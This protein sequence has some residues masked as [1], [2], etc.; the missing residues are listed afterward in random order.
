MNILSAALDSK[1]SLTPVRLGENNHV[2]YDWSYN[3]DEQI[4]QFFFQLVRTKNHDDLRSRLNDMLK[5]LTWSE[6]RVQLVTLLKILVQ[7]RDIVDGKGEYDLAYMQILVWYNYYPT[8]A[9]NMF[10]LFLNTTENPLDHQYG[11]WKDVKRFCQYIKENTLDG[12]DHVLIRGILAYSINSLR[13]EYEKAMNDINYNPTLIGKWLPREKSKYGW[14]FKKMAMMMNPQFMS[15]ATSRNTMIKA[16]NKQKMVL[17]KRLVYLNKRVDTVQI[18]MCDRDGKWSQIDFN[19]VTS[20]TMSKSKNAI[21]YVDKKGQLRGENSDRIQCR[22]NYK[23]HL[24]AAM[25]GDSSK[26]IHGK[27]CQV[28]EL[29]REALKCYGT[30]SGSEQSVRNTINMQWESNKSNNKGLEGKSI[31]CMC[32]TSGSMEVD[33]CL[34]LHNAIGMSIRISE[35]VDEESGFKNRIMTFDSH[36]TWVQTDDSMDFV[37]KVKTVKSAAW[38]TSTDFFLALDKILEV[39]VENQIHPDV[40]RN[41]IFAVFSDMQYDCSYHN[42]GI[43][44][45]AEEKIKKRFAEG[46]MNTKWRQPYEMPHILFWNLRKTNGF[47]ATSLSKNITFLSGYSSTLMNV[48]CTKG[49]EALRSITP[50]TMLNDLLDSD[51]YNIVENYITV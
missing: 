32:D 24:S 27:R 13:T 8:L 21:L 7:T 29:V 47:P 37:A 31:V 35:L 42:A 18:K 3:V 28:G 19:K 45:T 6:N 14:V 20:H 9:F 41:L 33:D 46:G 43:F 16:G 48:F 34:P 23:A 36:P 38:G 5:R 22:E 39:L 4:C 1:K 49:I 17:K 10:K 2:E 11:S 25:S 15:T 51:R 30:S 50:I 12:E 40:V 26:K 44:D